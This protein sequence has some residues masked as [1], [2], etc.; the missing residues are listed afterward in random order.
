MLSVGVSFEQLVGEIAPRLRAA[1]VAAYGVEEGSDA[2]AD[3]IAWAWEHR[4]R[5]VSLT[6]PAGY[7]YR[8]GQTAA[9]RDRR[10]HRWLPEAP[11]VELPDVESALFDALDELSEQQRVCVLLVHALGWR[12]VEVADLLGVTPSTV[13][14]HQRLGLARLRR[15]LEVSLDEV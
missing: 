10:T 4:D 9:R 8:V 14:A 6:N 1:L 12:Q 5:V 7:L 15:S 3:A 2:A 13:A 11:A